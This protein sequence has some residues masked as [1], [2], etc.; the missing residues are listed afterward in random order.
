MYA[1][2]QAPLMLPEM[3]N[4]M[5]LT[6]RWRSVESYFQDVVG[7]V[8]KCVLHIKAANKSK[9]HRNVLMS[10]FYN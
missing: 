6:L 5:S 10:I 9:M 4:Q 1:C 7:R 2:D 8:S 3:Q